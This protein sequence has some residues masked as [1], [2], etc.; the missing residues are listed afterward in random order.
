M[1]TKLLPFCK[2]FITIIRKNV[3]SFM[4]VT[5]LDKHKDPHYPQLNRLLLNMAIY[6]LLVQF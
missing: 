1:E 6:L 3:L 5:I 2:I 4:A